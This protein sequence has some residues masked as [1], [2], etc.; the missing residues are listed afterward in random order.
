MNEALLCAG[1]Q[2]CRVACAH[3][4]RT[5]ENQLIELLPDKDR[6]R[7]LA[8]GEP[9]E[10]V[11][12]A[13]LVEP[14]HPASHVYFPR[15]GYVSLLTLLDGHPALEVGMVGPEG[16]V[17][18]PL[19]PGLGAPPLRAQVQAPG[20]AWRVGLGPFRRQLAESPAL[21]Q[22]IE[23]YLWVCVAQLASAAA[24]LH[25]HMIA[26]R[27]ARRLLMSQD[28][29]Q[30]DG[31]HV[32]HELLASMLGV[33]RVGITVAAGVLQRDGLIRYHRGEITV[34]DRAGLEAAACSCYAGD[35]QAYAALLHG[36]ELAH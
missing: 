12:P 9:F 31:F 20:T 27:L 19:A 2:S 11:L 8:A 10:L 16:V 28:R 6:S 30:A 14:G 23:R 24:C 22:L 4:A 13:V 26:P 1:R 32:T 34:L 25:F 3:T 36:P 21:R 15:V 7:L 18:V 33:R 35:R 29:A 17:G 5:V